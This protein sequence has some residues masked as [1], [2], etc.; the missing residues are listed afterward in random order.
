VSAVY[1]FSIDLEDVRTHVVNGKAFKERVPEN[2]E[3]YLRFLK[4]NASTCTFFVV[5]EILRSYPELIE[6]I[7][8][9][10]HEIACHSDMHVPLDKLGRIGFSNDIEAWLH[11][12]EAL[13]VKNVTGFRAPTFS[14]TAQTPWAYQILREHGFTYS[15]SVLP[16]GNPLYGWPGFGE[17]PRMV[18]GILELPMN[19]SSFGPL[20]VP[21]G[22]GIYFR[23]LP[24]V[25]LRRMFKSSARNEK[26]VLG[27]FHPYDVD[28]EQ[29]YFMH[30]GLGDSRF[31]NA[32]MYHGR[33]TVFSK[34][35]MIT[36][37][38][39]A[40]QRY[41]TYTSGIMTSLLV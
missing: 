31:Y 38:G 11:S 30:P 14:L 41:D 26:A 28:T 21:F 19:L 33:N 13:G 18:D 35:S 40:F 2:T 12:A 27:Y 29:E 34:L 39:F 7:M 15:S 20:K 5:G 10:G 36:D 37:M 1:L 6:L 8:Q 9:N 16:A 24:P 4:E 32:L 3:L 17:S 25:V 23:L 22:G